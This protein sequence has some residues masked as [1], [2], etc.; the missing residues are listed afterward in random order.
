MIMENLLDTLIDQE[1]HVDFREF[2]SFIAE[3]ET[4]IFNRNGLIIFQNPDAGRKG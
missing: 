4:H 2:V 3:S 1:D